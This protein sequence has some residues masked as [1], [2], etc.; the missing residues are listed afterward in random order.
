MTKIKHRNTQEV[1]LSG[2]GG[3]KD[4]LVQGIKAGAYLCDADLRG[5]YLCDAYLCDAYLCDADLRGANLRDA[6]LGDANLGGANLGGA[7][8]RGA[9]LGGAYLPPSI[10]QAKWGIPDNAYTM[11]IYLNLLDIDIPY[12]LK[13]GLLLIPGFCWNETIPI[14]KANPKFVK[15]LKVVWKELH[16]VCIEKLKGV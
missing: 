8:L 1:L 14:L 9:Y 12:D 13:Q 4:L 3:I 6:N 2:E 16:D 7:N 15:R 10:M 5:A 11:L